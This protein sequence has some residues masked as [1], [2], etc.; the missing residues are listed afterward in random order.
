MKTFNLWT[1]WT[2]LDIKQS[3]EIELF[4]GYYV[5]Q[6]SIESYLQTTEKRNKVVNL[7]QGTFLL[8]AGKN[9]LFNNNNKSGNQPVRA[10][11]F[12]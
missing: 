4:D 9:G 7:W 2:L 3:T 8:K 12:V 10:I 11:E 6:I 1:T 5:R